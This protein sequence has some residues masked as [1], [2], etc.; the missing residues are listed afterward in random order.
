MDKLED[1]RDL[2]VY[3]PNLAADLVDY[4]VKWDLISEHDV[5]ALLEELQHKAE[6]DSVEV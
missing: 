2:V 6:A 5:R 1:I 3:Y 4:L